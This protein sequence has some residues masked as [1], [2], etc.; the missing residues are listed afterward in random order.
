[1]LLRKTQIVVCR[2]SGLWTVHNC[3]LVHEYLFVRILEYMIII[4]LTLRSATGREMN[5][6]SKATSAEQVVCSEEFTYK[7]GSGRPDDLFSFHFARKV[8]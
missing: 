4:F 2:L 3:L 6:S 8:E 5:H 1:M 7:E